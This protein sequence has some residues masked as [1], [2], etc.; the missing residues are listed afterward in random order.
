MKCQNA[1]QRA[2]SKWINR[3]KCNL[4]TLHTSLLPEMAILGVNKTVR[5]AADLPLKGEGTLALSVD[6]I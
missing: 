4:D 3:F 1:V 5:G 6:H 2:T